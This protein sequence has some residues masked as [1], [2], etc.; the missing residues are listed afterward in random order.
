M[1]TFSQTIQMDC[2]CNHMYSYKV[3]AEED[4]T[5][6]RGEI[7]TSM[8]AKTGVTQSQ[9]AARSSTTSQGMLATTRS[10]KRQGMD[11]LPLP[12]EGA[13]AC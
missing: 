6:K 7:N 11:S 8:E 12:P 2:T 4:L 10:W 5:H 9:W 13:K 1:G 3:R